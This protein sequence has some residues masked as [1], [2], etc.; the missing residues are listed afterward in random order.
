MA[1]TDIWLGCF[2]HA[3]GTYEVFASQDCYGHEVVL[4]GQKVTT[5]EEAD[6][7]MRTLH[8]DIWPEEPAHA[9]SLPET[10]LAACRD[11]GAS[12]LVMSAAYG[13][14]IEDLT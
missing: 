13:G 3:D 7:L 2:A 1:H 10:R 5:R 8:A 12:T 11:D 14:P 4:F 6:S 9:Y